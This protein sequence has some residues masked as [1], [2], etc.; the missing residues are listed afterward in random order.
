MGVRIV[1][2]GGSSDAEVVYEFDQQ[3]IVIGRGAGA[4]VRIPQRTV[5]ETHAVLRLEGTTWVVQD[6]GST[7]GTRVNGTRVVAGRPKA[8]RS[9]D[10]LE[11][12]GFVLAFSTG[13]AISESTSADRTAAL[14]RRLVREVLDPAGTAAS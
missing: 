11:L 3:R 13:V 7:N 9:G 12:G 14:A 6:E 10:T 4:D 8:L 2:R 5:S 1:V